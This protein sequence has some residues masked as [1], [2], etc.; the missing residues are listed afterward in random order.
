METVKDG[1]PTSVHQSLQRTLGSPGCGRLLERLRKRLEHGRPLTGRLNLAAPTPEE[2]AEVEGLLGR[3]PGQGNDLSISLDELDSQIRQAGL[4][5]SLEAAVVALT[6]PLKNLRAART[7]EEARWDELFSAFEKP[8]GLLPPDYLAMLRARGL[9]KRLGCPDAARRRLEQIQRLVRAL[10]AAGEP[11][12]HIAAHLFGDSH[13]LDPGQPLANLALRLLP[14]LVSIEDDPDATRADARRNAWASAGVVCDGLSAPPI[15]L[16]LPARG[17]HLLGRLL[18]LAA[19][20][21]EPVHLSLRQVVKY[22][23]S[24]DSGL[25]GQTVYVC[26][27]PTILALAAN[28]HGAACAPIVCINGEPATPARTLLRQL[29]EAGAHLR[30]HGDFDW[31]GISIAS[32]VF[33]CCEARPWRF[34]ATSYLA[35]PKHKPLTGAA[36]PTPWDP[37]LSEVIKTTGKSVHEEAVAETLLDDLRHYPFLT[38]R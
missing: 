36:T 6:G 35:A 31:R 18:R 14:H 12:A 16:N 21:G 26:E 2:R 7:Q 19:G 1:M 38:E 30:Y 27:N 10:P 29:R 11:M 15:V 3:P 9:L 13:A 5:N 32:R 25:R 23:L 20:S 24:S 34:D 17:D 4:A 8:G 37:P 28:A 33:R 22:P